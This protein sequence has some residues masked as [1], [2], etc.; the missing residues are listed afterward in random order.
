M[1][2]VHIENFYEGSLSFDNGLPK[3]TKKDKR[4]HGFGMK[5]IRM[6]TEKY[7]GYFKVKAEN[8]LFILNILIQLPSK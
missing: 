2:V 7:H 5:S 8:G 3:T 4:Y 1:F 6:I